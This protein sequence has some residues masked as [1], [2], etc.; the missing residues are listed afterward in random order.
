MAVAVKNA[1]ETATTSPFDRL[2]VVCLVGVVYILGF[3]PRD[4]KQGRIS[5]KV[6]GLPR[7]SEI[8]YR[9]G[10][11]LACARVLHSWLRH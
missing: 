8:A 10:Y 7:G 1:P 11:G 5:V 4:R 9:E 6:H 2:P 3:H